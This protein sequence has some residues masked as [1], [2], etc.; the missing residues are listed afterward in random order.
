MELSTT[1]YTEGSPG[2]GVSVRGPRDGGAG[3]MCPGVKYNAQYKNAHN[4]KHTRV[5]T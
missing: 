5:H 2:G 4:Q 3:L 1:A